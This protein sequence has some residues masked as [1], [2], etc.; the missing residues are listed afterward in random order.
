MIFGSMW[1]FDHNMIL[2]TLISF[3]F[4]VNKFGFPFIPFL[5]L[6]YTSLDK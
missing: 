5:C 2:K 4:I 1:Y 3:V 6:R